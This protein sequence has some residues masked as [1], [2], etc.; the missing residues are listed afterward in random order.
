MKTLDE[1]D[2]IGGHPA[3]DFVNTV[4]SWAD[5]ELPDYLQDFDDFV[6]WCEMVGLISDATPFIRG[7]PEPDKQKAFQ[8]T[9]LL[10]NSVYGIFAAIA[11]NLPLPKPALKHLN[12]VVLRTASWRRLAASDDGPRIASQWHFDNAP[13]EA[14]LG[15]V[16]WKTAELLEIGPVD[17]LKICPGADCAWVFIDLSKNRSRQWCSMATCGNAAKVRRFRQRNEL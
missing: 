5:P 10:R 3:V 14:L 9:R 17:R 8:E 4:H 13:A 1:L 2:I 15:P 11:G 16:A 7:L 6:R 12:D